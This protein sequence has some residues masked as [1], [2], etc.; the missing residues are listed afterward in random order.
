MAEHDTISYLRHRAKTGIYKPTPCP[1][2]CCNDRKECKDI[3]HPTE[4]RVW[5]LVF[6]ETIQTTKKKRLG[7][8]D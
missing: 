7:T 5:K 8:W 6:G 1:L 3:N 4:C 2:L